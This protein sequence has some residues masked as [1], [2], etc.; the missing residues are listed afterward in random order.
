MLLEHYS[1]GRFGD[2]RLD[3]GGRL[4]SRAWSCARARACGGRRLAIDRR[5]SAMVDFGQRK[6][7]G[8]GLTHGLGRAN[9]RC[10]SRPACAESKTPARS[11]FER[12]LSAVAAWARSAKASAAACCCMRC[13]RWMRITL[14]VWDWLPARSGHARAGLRCRTRNGGLMRRNCGAGSA[15]PS[16]P[17]RSLARRQWSPLLMTARATFMP[18]G[19]ASRSRILIC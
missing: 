11:I 1:V 7:D 10:G 12:R 17:R 13:W 18:N 4:C 16:G 8:G 2:R 14:P 3:K 6:G 9:R 19:R 15:R 5:S